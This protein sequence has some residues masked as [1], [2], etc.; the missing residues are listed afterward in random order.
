MKAIKY[1]IID[2]QK[3]IWTFKTKFLKEFL[4]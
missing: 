4:K 1:V 2:N 3:N